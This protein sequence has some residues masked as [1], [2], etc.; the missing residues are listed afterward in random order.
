MRGTSKVNLPSWARYYEPLEGY[1]DTSLSKEEYELRHHAYQC[2]AQKLNM[3][4]ESTLT[5]KGLY[6]ATSDEDSSSTVTSK[7]NDA[8]T[9]PLESFFVQFQPKHSSDVKSSSTVESSSNNSKRRKREADISN[10]KDQLSEYSLENYIQDLCTES[11]FQHDPTILPIAIITSPTTSIQD[12]SQVVQMIQKQF[13]HANYPG[14]SRK[15]NLI[16]SSP[17]LLPAVCRISTA[18][19]NLYRDHGECIKSILEQCISQESNPYPYKYLLQ[20]RN[21]RSFLGGYSQRLMEYASITKEKKSIIV[22]FENMEEQENMSSGTSKSY[23]LEEGKGFILIEKVMGILKDL[24]EIGIPICVTIVCTELGRERVV[25]RLDWIGGEFAVGTMVKDFFVKSGNSDEIMLEKLQEDII[26]DYVENLYKDFEFPF[27]I[28]SSILDE[29]KRNFV[30][31][32]GSLAEFVLQLKKVMAKKF[33]EKGSFLALLGCEDFKKSCGMNALWYCSD[34]RARNL[35]LSNWKVNLNSRK[36]VMQELLTL[37]EDFQFWSKVCQLLNFVRL[38]IGKRKGSSL[39]SSVYAKSILTIGHC[40][41]R[42][43]EF[44][45]ILEQFYDHIR[46]LPIGDLIALIAS[47]IKQV[48]SSSSINEAEKD[49]TLNQIESLDCNQSWLD[50]LMLHFKSH[51]CLLVTTLEESKDESNADSSKIYLHDLRESLIEGLHK[52]FWR[53]QKERNSRSDNFL[54]FSFYKLNDNPLVTTYLTS[55]KIQLRRNIAGSISLPKSLDD[56]QAFDL[57]LVFKTMDSRIKSINEWF[58]E[59]IERVFSYV[60]EGDSI[61]KQ[62]LIHRFTFAL[63]QLIYTGFLVKSRRRD[64]A[65]EKAAMCWALGS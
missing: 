50:E 4:Y 20:K 30:Q 2:T 45:F 18:H 40:V 61:D 17:K 54:S 14:E 60:S 57:C 23:S 56:D 25:E 51:L 3:C 42:S 38:F 44:V 5:G 7:Q 10:H 35:I 11:R 32:H 52:S 29:M 9:G 43:N 37:K 64:N 39:T 16:H 41:N 58:E 33:V 63:Y 12:R 62:D 28:D 21:A 55:E 19:A 15:R 27:A 22:I 26:N 1:D 36:E 8:M 59:Y 48:K 65:C 53:G 46:Q 6:S 49:T 13:L 34:E 31:Y 47:C 24:R